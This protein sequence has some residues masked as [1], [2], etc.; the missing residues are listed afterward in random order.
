MIRRTFLQEDPEPPLSVDATESMARLAF[1]FVP[2]N[3]FYRKWILEL[4]ENGTG[5][6]AWKY[7][8][9]YARLARAQGEPN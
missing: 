5:I 1:P 3:S 2:R 9:L 4:F 6:P 7:A 8:R